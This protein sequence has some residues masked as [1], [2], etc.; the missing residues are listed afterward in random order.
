MYSLPKSHCALD[1]RSLWISISVLTL[2]YVYL[3]HSGIWVV[4]TRFAHSVCRK[5]LMNL[6]PFNVDK[7]VNKLYQLYILSPKSSLKCWLVKVDRL[8]FNVPLK[9]LS[10]GKKKQYKLMVSTVTMWIASESKKDL[11]PF[12]LLWDNFKRQ[13]INICKSDFSLPSG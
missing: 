8:F 11:K 12:L 6:I 10:N 2:L 1:W 4:S 3:R 13:K 5:L 7:S 9:T